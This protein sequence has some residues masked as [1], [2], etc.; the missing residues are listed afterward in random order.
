MRRPWLPAWRTRVCR[1][2]LREAGD[3]VLAGVE[4]DDVTQLADVVG[5]SSGSGS[6]WQADRPT[7][8]KTVGMAWEDA[9]VAAEVVARLA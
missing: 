3:L 9:V 1:A 7:V 5:R 4:P 6:E 8:V 2:A